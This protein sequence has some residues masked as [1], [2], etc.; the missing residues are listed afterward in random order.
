MIE[1]IDHTGT[2]LALLLHSPFERGS[3]VGIARPSSGDTVI[4]P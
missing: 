4:I 3:E 1:W 2:G